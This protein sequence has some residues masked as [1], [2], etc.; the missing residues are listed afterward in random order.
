MSPNHALPRFAACSG[1]A[2]ALLL[3]MAAAAGPAAPA[4]NPITE[5]F[6]YNPAPDPD[7]F[8]CG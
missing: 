8:T 2:L 6:R 3:P 5:G 7:A 1:I 4:I